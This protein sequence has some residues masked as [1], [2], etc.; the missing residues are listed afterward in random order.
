VLR[1]VATS[2]K[3]NVKGHDIAA[4]YGGEEFAVVLPNMPLSSAVGLADQIRRAVETKELKKR[5]T[6]ELLGRVTISIGVAALGA[7]DTAQMLIE[8]A[9]GCLYSAKRA[10][11]NQVIGEPIAAAA[12]P[13]KVA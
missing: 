3:Q 1:L 5:S 8:R 4:R 7:S 13:A 6:G 2:L 12:A 10:G 9:D 11:R